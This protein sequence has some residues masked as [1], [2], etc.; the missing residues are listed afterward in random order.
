M[1]LKQSRPVGSTHRSQPTKP[2]SSILLLLLLECPRSLARLTSSIPPCACARLCPVYPLGLALDVIFAGS[3]LH[4]RHS[5][6]EAH[7]LTISVAYRH[8]F[9][10]FTRVPLSHPVTMAVRGLNK[11][12]ILTVC[13]GLN[14]DPPLRGRPWPGHWSLSVCYF[15]E[16]RGLGGPP[17]GEICLGYPLGPRA[18]TAFL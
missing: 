3:L 9:S 14:N 1:T 13:G 5:G 17:R 7:P 18:I 6:L 15:A 12:G 4:T 2:V 11:S 10:L 16:Q 8:R